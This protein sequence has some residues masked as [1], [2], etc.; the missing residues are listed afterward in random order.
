MALQITPR[1]DV[2]APR[3]PLPADGTPT[4]SFVIPAYNEADDIITTLECALAQRLRPREIIV[5]DDGST[6]GTLRSCRNCATT[7]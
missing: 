3:K 5:V 2:A 4:F 6:D 7:G 1:Q